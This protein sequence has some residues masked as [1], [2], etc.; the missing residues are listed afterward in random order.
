[1]NSPQYTERA[2]LRTK[3]F[4]GLGASGGSAID[5]VFGV[6]VFFYYQQIL[7][8]S[9]A[10]AGTAVALSIVSDAVT[11]PLIGSFSD[12][13]KSKYGRRHPFMFMAPI[14]LALSLFLIFNPPESIVGSQA[15]LF[16]WFVTFTILLRTFQ[17]FFTI[18]Y[19][20]LGAELSTDYIERSKI[21]SFN[22]LFGMFGYVF[23]HLVA[24]VV[25]F[26]MLF[27]GEGGRLYQP[28]YT[29]VVLI[30]CAFIVITMFF[31]A[32]GTRDQ[33]EKLKQRETEMG[34][35]NLSS[36]FRDIASV[37]K[38]RNYRA[39]LLGMFFM[40][41]T[42]G[43]HETLGMYMATFFWEL[44]SYQYGLLIFGNI[45][46]TY[47]AFYAGSKLHEKFDKRMTIFWS[48]LVFAV[49]WSL[50]SILALLGLAPAVASWAAVLF[51]SVIALVAVFAG[52]VLSISVMSSLADIADE[53]ELQTGRRQEGIF[54]SARSFFAKAMG[55]LGA[56]VAGFAVDLYIKIPPNSVPGE[57]AEDVIFR[58][59]IVD[60]PFAMI[61]GIVA[62]F[63]YLRYRIDKKQ[64]Q[65]IRSQLDQRA[66]SV[67][68]ET[69]VAE[70]SS[71]PA[72]SQDSPLMMA[73]TTHPT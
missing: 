5:W 14:P 60:G 19:L 2:S 23:T 51:I 18:P 64:H 40:A 31:S 37:L 50:T 11:D 16:A 7:G 67:N 54:Y 72:A 68:Q 9:G 4:F 6:L 69:S 3:L 27:E 21:M 55:A 70:P 43:T 36:V 63:L 44:D 52:V 32:Y 71:A 15:Y 62:A 46:G 13:Y 39:L 49:F 66:S 17:T 12:R 8:L 56:F 61:W 24:M 73:T 53:H 57:V 38:N 42:A 26:G 29:P 45:I 1:M 25:I 28:A 33:I 34:P 59:G 58:L 47:L 65:E 10:L 20:A 48:C 22:L 41:L 35:S 30:S